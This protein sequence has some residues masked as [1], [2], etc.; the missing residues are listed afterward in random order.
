MARHRAGEPL[1]QKSFRQAGQHEMFIFNTNPRHTSELITAVQ[2]WQFYLYTLCRD[3]WE[4]MN[5]T[6]IIKDHTSINRS[7][8]LMSWRFS[9]HFIL[10]V[11][12]YPNRYGCDGLGCTYFCPY[13][14]NYFLI[15]HNKW[16]TKRFNLVV[17]PETGS[18][19]T[20]WT[21]HVTAVSVDAFSSELIRTELHS[22]VSRTSK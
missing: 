5:M 16:L 15:F 10:K 11:L 19:I 17:K 20:S 18:D 6:L 8:L 3:V 4:D 12:S 7:L 2:S 21:N 1:K 13:I 9:S 22:R 14:V